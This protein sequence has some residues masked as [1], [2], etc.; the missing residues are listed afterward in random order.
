MLPLAVDPEVPDR[1]HSR[2]VLIA[3][4]VVFL[5]MGFI[6]CLVYCARWRRKVLLRD[7]LYM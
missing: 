3:L 5:A 1:R 6:A 2:P 7:T 4:G